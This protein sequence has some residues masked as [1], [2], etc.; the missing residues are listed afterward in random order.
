[1]FQWKEA[2]ISKDSKFKVWCCAYFAVR[3]IIKG[4]PKTSTRSSLV[5]KKLLTQSKPLSMKG[6]W[7]DLASNIATRY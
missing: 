7:S 5:S 4:D 2:G 1:M 6:G 3:K